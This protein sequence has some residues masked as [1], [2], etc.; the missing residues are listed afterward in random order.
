VKWEDRNSDGRGVARATDLKLELQ[1][2]QKAVVLVRVRMLAFFKL[3]YINGGA[4]EG[5]K[6]QSAA[7]AL[8]SDPRYPVPES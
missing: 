4:A 8:I 6:K 2:P 1:P 7:L 3:N 5:S